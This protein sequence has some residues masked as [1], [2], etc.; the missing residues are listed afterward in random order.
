MERLPIGSSR[1][2]WL[3]HVTGHAFEFCRWWFRPIRLGLVAPEQRL[4]NP[5]RTLLNLRE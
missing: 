4:G 3:T 5:L 1:W 2:S